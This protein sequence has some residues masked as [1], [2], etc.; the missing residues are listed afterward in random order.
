MTHKK[1]E[2]S[3]TEVLDVLFRGMKIS[4]VAWTFF[5]EGLRIRK[6]LFLNKK[7]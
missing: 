7:I 5:Y 4:P 2:N 1:E 6:L 3:N